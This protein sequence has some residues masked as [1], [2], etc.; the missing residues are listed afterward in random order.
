MILNAQSFLI[1]AS[2]F[3]VESTSLDESL[4]L[5]CIGDI[6]SWFKL[7]LPWFYSGETIVVCPS[8]SMEELQRSQD[9]QYGGLAPGASS[10]PPGISSFLELYLWEELCLC[11]L[12]Q[13]SNDYA[14]SMVLC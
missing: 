9:I 11:S 8:Q 7:I 2:I 6:L 5:I 14:H 13:W 4:K 12:I 10:A 1:P 3:K